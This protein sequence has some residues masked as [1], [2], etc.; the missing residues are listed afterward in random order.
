MAFLFHFYDIFTDF[1]YLITI[2]LFNLGIMMAMITSLILPLFPLILVV[3]D[4]PDRYL[5][6]GSRIL[7]VIAGYIGLGPLILVT[8]ESQGD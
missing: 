8:A 6:F 3:I 1:Q 4:P 5:V 7:T 2:P